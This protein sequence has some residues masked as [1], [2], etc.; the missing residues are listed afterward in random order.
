ML[1]GAF[2]PSMAVRVIIIVPS[3]APPLILSRQRTMAGFSL[4]RACAL[5]GPSFTSATRYFRQRC[6]RCA[7]FLLTH[8]HYVIAAITDIQ[9]CHYDCARDSQMADALPVPD[10]LFKFSQG[11]KKNLSRNLFNFSE[12]ETNLCEN[13]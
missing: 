11:L 8:L 1:V 12:T 3:A 7:F 6:N 10:W 5:S 13:V 9:G 4:T 2:A